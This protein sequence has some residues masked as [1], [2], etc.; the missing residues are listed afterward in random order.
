MDSDH[1]HSVGG[2][3]QPN[4][5]IANCETNEDDPA[6]LL[7]LEIQAHRETAA[8][9]DSC[10]VEIR[11]LKQRLL[12]LSVIIRDLQLQIQNVISDCPMGH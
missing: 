7:T 6:L 9:R 3:L 8:Q 11:E 10:M 4:K 2:R 5:M 12:G 1:A